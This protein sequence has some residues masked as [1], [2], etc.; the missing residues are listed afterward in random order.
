MLTWYLLVF[1]GPATAIENPPNFKSQAKGFCGYKGEDATVQMLLTPPSQIEIDI[2]ERVSIACAA[3]GV[4]Q[5]DPYVYWVKG[6]GP[7]FTE[8]GKN[9]G[10]VAIGKSVLYIDEADAD[11]IDTYQCVVESCC[12]KGTIVTN[13]DISVGDATCKDVYGIGHTVYSAV[14]KFLTWQEAFD[15]CESKGME[16]ASPKSME[17]NNELLANVQKSFGRHPN[18]NKF[19]HENYIWLAYHDARREGTFESEPD[20]EVA[21]F[22]NFD[23][24]QPDNWQDGQDGVGM[25]RGTGLWDDSF[26]T[27]KRPYAC[28]CPEDV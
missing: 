7:D 12:G 24:K 25:H 26:M 14:W 4:N 10:P 8:K 23:K 15:D 3:T 28:K 13:V 1:L 19:A 18:A 22:D 6:L 21:T 5:A 11:D 27:Y 17:E 20:G 9:M 2:G 16:M